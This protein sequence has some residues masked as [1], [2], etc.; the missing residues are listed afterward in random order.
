[1]KNMLTVTLNLLDFSIALDGE[2]PRPLWYLHSDSRG[3]L[4]HIKVPTR[5]RRITHHKAFIGTGPRTLQSQQGN[6]SPR[7]GIRH[8]AHTWCSRQRD[9]RR[10][11]QHGP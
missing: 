8:P 2:L 9:E 4:T 7:L 3:L 5:T 1:M 11:Q 6:R 10:S